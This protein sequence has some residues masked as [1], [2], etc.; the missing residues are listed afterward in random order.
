MSN[1]RATHARVAHF[2]TAFTIGGRFPYAIIALLLAM[3]GTALGGCSQIT[4]R[5]I[6]IIQVTELRELQS[7]Q[8]SA[9]S[10]LVLVDPRSAERYEAG[11]IPGAIRLALTQVNPDGPRR[12]ELV[13]HQE[14]VV[15]GDNPGSHVGRAMTKRLMEAGYRNVRFFAGGAEEYGRL[16]GLQ[17]L[18]T[19][20]AETEEASRG[21]GA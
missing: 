11:H 17:R 18:T 20:P 15:Y 21:S 4:D 13:G 8:A 1:F 2:D 12:P 6:R 9:P 3:L 7:R 16:Y 5:D 14:I 10:A 19:P